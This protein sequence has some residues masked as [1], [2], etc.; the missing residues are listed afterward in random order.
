MTYCSKC[1]KQVQDGSKIC[2]N[3]GQAMVAQP[4]HSAGNTYGV[5]R[6]P[7]QPVQPVINSYGRQN[8]LNQPIQPVVNYGYSNIAENETGKNKSMVYIIISCVSFILSVIGMA[9]FI[10]NKEYLGKP[11]MV[12]EIHNEYAEYY[13]GLTAE[14]MN[15]IAIIGIIAFLLFLALGVF[16]IIKHIKTNKQQ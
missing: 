12:R 15:A 7:I 14:A 3:C 16:F 13:G 8:T 5:Q 11:A 1:G 6:M 2:T 9:A 4:V 10:I